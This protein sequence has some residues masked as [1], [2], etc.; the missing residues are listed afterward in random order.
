MA[1]EETQVQ[2]ETS[3]WAFDGLPDV[4]PS[5]SSFE[6]PLEWPEALPWDDPPE[7]WSADWLSDETGVDPWA[8]AGEAPGVPDSGWAPPPAGDVDPGFD[9]EATEL[10]Q[11]ALPASIWSY[12]ESERQDV[13]AVAPVYAEPERRSSRRWPPHIDLR[14]GNAAMVAVASFVSLVLLGMFLSVRARN[15]VPVDS[16]QTQTTTGQIA[17]DRPLNTIPLPVST[18]TSL[19]PPSTISLSDLLPPTDDGQ[20]AA[21]TGTTPSAPR[22]GVTATTAAPA[23]PA[24]PTG[25]G[26]GGGTTG[27]TQPTTAT[28]Q[29]AP[30]PEPD[31]EPVPTTPTTPPQDT[32]QTTATPRP[33]TN[34]TIPDISIPTFPTTPTTQSSIPRPSIPGW[35]G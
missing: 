31:P 13:A 32:T 19:A 29:A 6:E 35:P 23:R 26:S 16:S 20:T 18:P 5:S 34:I 30:E 1:D 28:T 17:A 10:R 25:G 21:T 2:E 24:A 12:A 14:H 7:G 4:P 8:D 3:W 33:P 22:S 9:G 27:T 15:N 11:E